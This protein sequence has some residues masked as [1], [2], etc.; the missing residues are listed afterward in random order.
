MQIYKD[1]LPLSVNKCPL[2][3]AFCSRR[4]GQ[5]GRFITPG[6]NEENKDEATWFLEFHRG[7]SNPA[8]CFTMLLLSFASCFV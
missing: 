1:G 2:L 5:G 3:P 8:W 6:G 7:L 4:P